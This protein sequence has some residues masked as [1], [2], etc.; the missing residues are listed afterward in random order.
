MKIIPVPVR[1]DNYSYII[2]SSPSQV[3]GDERQ[4]ACFVDPYDLDKV[5]KV[6]QE[7]YGIR[8]ED[9]VGCLTTHHHHD[10]SGGNEDFA[11]AYPNL[12]I[13]GGSDKCPKMTKQLQHGSTFDLLPNVTVKCYGT[14]C[15]TQD[16]ICY[17]LEDKRDEAELA[18]LGQGLKEGKDGEKKRGVMTGD[19]LFI[20]GCGRFF[21]GSAEE[22]NKALN[23]TLAS[24]PPTT[25]VYCG[26]EYTKSNVAFSAAVLPDHAPIQNLIRDVQNQ[27]NGGVT[28]GIYTIADEKLHNVFMRLQDP[29]VRARVGGKDEVDTMIKLRE[30]KN[31]GSLQANI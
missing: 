15:H 24:L 12:P 14:P 18:K 11:K 25:L 6:A 7:E 26:H 9:V 30:A 17:Y 5:R 10:H 31:S 4:K 28:T 27:R 3:E 20:S 8:D 1:S 23:Q 16:S 19:T 29:A 2:L 22:M 21:E 13:W